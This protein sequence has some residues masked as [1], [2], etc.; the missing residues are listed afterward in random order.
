M[1]S[2]YDSNEDRQKQGWVQLGLIDED[3]DYGIDEHT[4]MYHPTRKVFLLREASGCSCWEGV[5]GEEEY[6]TLAAIEKELR[7][8]QSSSLPSLKG[9]ESLMQESSI[10]LEAM[11]RH[12]RT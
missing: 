8:G 9:T 7:E 1:P 12:E 4:I 6:P 11:L 5:Y 2:S 3:D 10:M